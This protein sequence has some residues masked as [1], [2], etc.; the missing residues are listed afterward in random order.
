[1]QDFTHVY[2]NRSEVFLNQYIIYSYTG[3]STA[4]SPLPYNNSFDCHLI[5][6]HIQFK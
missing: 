1:M 4:R 5:H 2:Q 3:L 6:T